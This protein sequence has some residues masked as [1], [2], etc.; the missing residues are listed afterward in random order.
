M[1]RLALWIGRRQQRWANNFVGR[2]FIRRVTT[3]L[4]AWAVVRYHLLGIGKEA[5]TS[6]PNIVLQWL[7]LAKFFHAPVEVESA[8][9]GLV[10]VCHHECTMGFKP[11]QGKLCRSSMNMDVQIVRRLGGKMTVEHTLAEG[12]DHCRHVIEFGEQS[13]GK[14]L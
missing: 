8:G 3:P 12:A 10:V 13:P 2:F 11:G 1:R 9:A 6:A 7:R 5:P 14:N 4:L